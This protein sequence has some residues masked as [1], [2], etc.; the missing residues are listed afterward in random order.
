MAVL[1]FLAFGAAIYANFW[2]ENRRVEE[3]VVEGNRV[4]PSRDILALAKVPANA[5]LFDLDLFEIERR[6]ETNDFV[7][8]AAVHRDIPHRVRITV[9]ERIPV[10]AMTL[11]GRLY[12]LDDEGFVLPP[13]RSPF[14]FD[15]PV[16][17]GSESSNEFVPGKQT[18]N[19]NAL[20]ALRILAIAK[21]ISQDVY[22]N[23]SEIRLDG[24][25]DIILYTSDG[26]VPVL[27]ARDNIGA[28]LVTFEAF[29]HSEVARR[30]ADQLQVVDLRFEH[31]VVVRWNRNA[32][33]THS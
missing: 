31:Q 9:E 8:S 19:R 32:G 26:A 13:T 28:Q 10:A 22:G 15:L 5:L 33:D 25:A 14:I 21:D 24:G 27:L 6:V 2:K 29:W 17:T 16:L 3:V 20:E 7:K 30:G 11:N 18:K 1:A 4:I 12:Y 23:I